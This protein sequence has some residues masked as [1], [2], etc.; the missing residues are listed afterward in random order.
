MQIILE[1]TNYQKKYKCPYCDKRDTRQNLVSHI[2]DDHEDMIPKDYTPLR[3]VFNTVN[4]KDHGNCII[5]KGETKWDENKGRYDRLCGKK[6]CHDKYV[7]MAHKNTRIEERMR[8]PEFQQ[9]MLAGRS[10]SGEYKFSDGGR[11]SYVGSY[12]K[13]LLEFMDKFLKVKSTDIQSPGVVIPYEYNGHEHFW[14]TD[15]YY[16]PFNLVFD[17]KDG[18]SNPNK[19][20]MTDYREKQKAKEKAI[21]KMGKYNYIRLTDNNFE[22][23]IEI[24]LDL[25]NSMGEELN[26]PVIHINESCA[27]IMTALPSVNSNDVYIVNYLQNNTFAKDDNYKQAICKDYMSDMFTIVNGKLTKI[28]IEEMMQNED[29]HV[30]KYLNNLNIDYNELLELAELDT[31]FYSLLVD[32]P[33]FG[34]EDVTRDPLFKEVSGFSNELKALTEI[35]Q[36]TILSNIENNV[37]D[38]SIPPV[39]LEDLNESGMGIKY[40]MDI[41]GYYIM[42]EDTNLRSKSYSSVEDIPVSEQKIIREIL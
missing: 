16:I 27:A 35:L 6:S 15:F 22:Q 32:K 34:I 7:K 2:A 39:E 36:S 42:N 24:M 19:R 9:K 3:V 13:N 23:L 25:K 37:L 17:V 12:E 30:Y 1:K 18:G 29:V 14:I 20:E 10:I 40:M 8:D 5:C 4:K 38:I 41:D 11:V 28:S 33:C 31:D 21:V 26:K